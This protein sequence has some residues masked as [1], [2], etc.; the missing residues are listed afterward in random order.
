MLVDIYE[1]HVVYI[2]LE[3][4]YNVKLTQHISIQ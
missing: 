4:N 1:V 3:D 2:T